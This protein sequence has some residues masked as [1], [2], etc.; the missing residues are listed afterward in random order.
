MT[1]PD[2]RYRAIQ[3]TEQFLVDLCNSTSTPR[4]PKAIRAQARSLLR[5][6]PS[7]WDLDRLTEAAPDIIAKQ[8]EPLTRLIMQHEFDLDK[9][10]SNSV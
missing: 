2:E 9:K 3:R 8:L 5:H 4:V 10:D 7:K 6:Y 1:L